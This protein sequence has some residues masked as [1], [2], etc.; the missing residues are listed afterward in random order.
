MKWK[1]HAR[2]CKRSGFTIPRNVVV[3]AFN[4]TGPAEAIEPVDASDIDEDYGSGELA[5]LSSLRDTVTSI[6]AVLV[7][8]G[9]IEEYV[10]EDED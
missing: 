10:E 2:P 4:T 8:A 6:L 5:V 9:L 1:N 7:D 3:C